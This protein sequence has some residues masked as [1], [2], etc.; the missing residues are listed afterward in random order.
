MVDPKSYFGPTLILLE[1]GFRQ[2]EAKVPPPVRR[3][4]QDSFVFRYAEQT[5]HQAILQKLA[6][7][8]SGLHAVQVLLD[9]GLFQ[10]Q[11]MIQR[12]LDEIEEDVWFLALAVINKDV[13]PRHTEY[14]KY[15]YAEEFEDPDDIPGSHKSRGMVKREK[16]RAYVYKASGPEAARGSATGKI[17]AKAYS[18]FIHAASPHIMDMYGGLPAQFDVNGKSRNFRAPSQERDA[19]NLFYRAVLAMAVAAN[20]FGDNA[21]L[22]TM[23]AWAA[24]L[25]AAMKA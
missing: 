20:A 14:L 22:T 16:I 6:R 24:E 8:L 25:D 2:L 12:A 23:R 15:F 13:T 11:G 9:R 10:E 4:W 17:L 1:R 18:G 19:L 7:T 3:P 5:I 21:L